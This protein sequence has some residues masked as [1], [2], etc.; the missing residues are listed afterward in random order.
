[1]LQISENPNSYVL[2]EDHD[3]VYFLKYFFPYIAFELTTLTLLNSAF[4]I[5][6]KYNSFVWRCNS[7]VKMNE[8]AV[9]LNV[10]TSPYKTVIFLWNKLN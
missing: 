6:K 9:Q 4:Y 1:M 7:S 8:C 5:E 3:Q 2:M 10:D